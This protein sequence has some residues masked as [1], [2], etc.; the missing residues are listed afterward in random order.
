MP[1]SSNNLDVSTKAEIKKKI[2]YNSNSKVFLKFLGNFGC[3]GQTGFSAQ[4]VNTKMTIVR[5]K[6]LLDGNS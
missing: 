3:S 6:K 4:T 1:G 5:H 2:T